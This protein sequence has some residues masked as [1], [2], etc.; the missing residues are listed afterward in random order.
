MRIAAL[1]LPVYIVVCSIISGCANSIKYDVGNL[2]PG[3]PSTLEVVDRRDADQKKPKIMSASV[4]NCWYGIYRIG[5]EQVVPD[6]L[7]ILASELEEKLGEKAKGRK[8]VVNRFEIYN[9]IQRELRKAAVASSFGLLGALMMKHI[10]AGGC[11]DAFALDG[12]PA[13]KPSVVALVEVEFE[14]K[15]IKEKI[16][17]IEPDNGKG[18][19]ARSDNVRERVRLATHLAAKAVAERLA[20]Q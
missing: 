7:R 20:V 18:N 9:N 10:E 12:N 3:G 11:S 19:D 4:S 8:L 16:V 1:E 14:G 15:A 17:Q 5:D 2:S 6:R 13:N